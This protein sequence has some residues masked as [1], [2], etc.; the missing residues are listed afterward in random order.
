MDTMCLLQV[1]TCEEKHGKRSDSRNSWRH[2]LEEGDG[3]QQPINQNCDA[4]ARKS[5]PQSYVLA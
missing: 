3:K 5:K 4:D 1:G 2:W